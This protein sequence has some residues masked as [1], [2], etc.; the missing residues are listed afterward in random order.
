[1]IHSSKYHLIKDAGHCA[2]MDNPDEFNSALM[3]F[4]GGNK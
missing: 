4:I 2:N 3:T 1:M